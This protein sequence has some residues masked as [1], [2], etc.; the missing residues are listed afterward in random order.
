MYVSMSTLFRVSR[1]AHCAA[2]AREPFT[3]NL[4]ACQITRQIREEAS[5]PSRHLR[6]AV[7][8]L[9]ESE[10]ILLCNW[11]ASQSP[12]LLQLLGKRLPK[13]R[14]PR[15]PAKEGPTRETRNTVFAN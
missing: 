2:K 8:M 14:R 10:P 15:F 11:F 6:S 1:D 4:Y 12:A 13:Q 9:S 5:G 3:H 7:L